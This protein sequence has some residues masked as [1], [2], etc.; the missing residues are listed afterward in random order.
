MP[1]RAV[2]LAR[3]ASVSPRS[4]EPEEPQGHHKSEHGVERAI[5]LLESS[6]IFKREA[7]SEG[8]Q[9]PVHV[10]GIE[11]PHEKEAAGH[12][13]VDGERREKQVGQS[14]DSEAR[15]ERPILA[16]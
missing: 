5:A 4:A 12:R 2:A 1:E 9:R 10:Q 14:E 8:S 13:S 6:D 15:P 3:I 16:P 11:S 7:H